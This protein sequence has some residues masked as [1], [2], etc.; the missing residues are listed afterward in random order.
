MIVGNKIKTAKVLVPEM[1]EHGTEIKFRCELK[2]QT[3][4]KNGAKQNITR[5]LTFK[6]EHRDFGVWAVCTDSR[7]QHQDIELVLVENAKEV[8]SSK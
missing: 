5:V 4:K 6:V 3:K 2:R 7:A 1:P 8:K